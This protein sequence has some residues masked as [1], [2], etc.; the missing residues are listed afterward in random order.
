MAKQLARRFVEDIYTS[1]GGIIT[2]AAAGAAIS[3]QSGGVTKEALIIG[4]CIGALG[5]LAKDPKF[6]KK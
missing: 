2:G 5:Y 1:V 3:I 4:A 6:L